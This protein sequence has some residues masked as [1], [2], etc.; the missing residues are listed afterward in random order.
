MTHGNDLTE[1][2]GSL[3]ATSSNSVLIDDGSVEVWLPKS[4]IQN[5]TSDIEDWDIGDRITFEI[6]EWL[7]IDRG[8]V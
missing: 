1:I 8:L 7:A 2:T 6:P 3:L 5:I 4:Q